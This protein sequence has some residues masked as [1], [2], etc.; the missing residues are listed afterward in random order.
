MDNQYFITEFRWT[1]YAYKNLKCNIRMD[2]N[3]FDHDCYSS[4]SRFVTFSNI[5]THFRQQNLMNGLHNQP[6]FQKANSVC[7]AELWVSARLPPYNCS[8]ISFEQLVPGF[9]IISQSKVMAN[10]TPNWNLWLQ[11]RPYGSLTV[12]PAM[13]IMLQIRRTQRPKQPRKIP[14]TSSSH[15]EKKLISK[16]HHHEFLSWLM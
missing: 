15:Q 10:I 8:S 11:T 6:N 5:W 12:R 1:F 14:T 3:E 4:F 16:M 2:I 13:L 9:V 7:W